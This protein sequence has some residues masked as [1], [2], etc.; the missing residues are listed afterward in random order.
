LVAL[1]ASDLVVNARGEP[2]LAHALAHEIPSAD[3]VDLLCAFV[4]WHGLRL[5]E[6]QLAAHCRAG[7]RL[8]VIHNRVHRIH[9]TEGARLAGRAGRASQ[10][11]VRHAVHA[12]ARQ[13]VAV[14]APAAIP[15]LTSA[16]QIFRSWRSWTAWNGTCACRRWARRTLSRSSMPLSKRTGKVPNTSRMNLIGMPLASIAL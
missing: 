2:G 15:P 11:V 14:P 1:S 9:R 6:D 4:R 5:L 10:S 13:G 16:R 12:P 3:S 8:R 7:R